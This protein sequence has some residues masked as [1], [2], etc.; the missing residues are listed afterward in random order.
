MSPLV[1]TGRVHV[2]VIVADGLAVDVS[3]RVA[4]A[5]G[6]LQNSMVLALDRALS[7]TSFTDET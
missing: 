4:G 6:T 2:A 1:D 5:D 3:V 7:P